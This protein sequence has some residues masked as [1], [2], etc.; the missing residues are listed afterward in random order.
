[1]VRKHPIV[2]FLI[3][4]YLALVLVSLLDGIARI[5]LHLDGCARARI[6]VFGSILFLPPYT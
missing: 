6:F 1:M 5:F 4:P 3:L 2:I